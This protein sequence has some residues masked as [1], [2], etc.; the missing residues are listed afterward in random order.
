MRDVKRC[1]PGFMNR[2]FD[3][4][5]DVDLRRHIKRSGGFIKDHQIRLWAERHCRH[6]PL[7]LPARH[8][9]RVA[10]ANGFGVRQRE[11]AKQR[12][13][14][15]LGLGFGHHAMSD[16]GFDHLLHQL[17]RRVEAGG[18]GL[19]DIGHFFAA[20]IT[21]IALP[22]RTNI[23]PV[24]HDLPPGQAHAAAAKG[25]GRKPDGGFA[26]AA[27]ADQA[28]HPTL[29]DRHGNAID[30]HDMARRLARRI[31]RCFDF[32]VL[33]REERISHRGP[34]SDWRCATRSSRQQD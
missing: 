25:H 20:Q 9:M 15:G 8:L 1:H 32:Q 10:V 19:G 24:Q 2:P 12:H 6:H 17:F 30:Q 27:F 14:P 3:R 21:Q 18:S 33:E 26:R 11:L 31:S 23:A 22:G 5:Q 29:F 4:R 13:R 16:R 34:L 28:Q 7:Q